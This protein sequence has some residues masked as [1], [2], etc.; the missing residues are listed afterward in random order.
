MKPFGR[1]L[2]PSAFR[3]FGVPADS[4]VSGRVRTAGDKSKCL[5]GALNAKKGGNLSE[6]ALLMIWKAYRL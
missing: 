2:E 1:S 3:R 6:P 5:Y 4:M